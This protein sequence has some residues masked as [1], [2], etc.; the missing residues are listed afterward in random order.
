MVD[1]EIQLE[2]AAAQDL[3]AARRAD[4]NKELAAQQSVLQQNAAEID[5]LEKLAANK[6][7]I[8]TFVAVTIVGGGNAL[9]NYL[10]IGAVPIL[11]DAIDL[12]AGGSLSLLLMTLEGGVRWKAQIWVW[13]LTFVEFIP[14]ADIISP[15][16]FGAGIAL[17]IAWREG[18]KAQKKLTRILAAEATE[19]N[20]SGYEF[21]E[22]EV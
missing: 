9:L 13:V 4:Q 11:G 6:E 14:A 8:V 18:T 12:L 15:Q 21:G 16:A 2:D 22:G 3:R 1:E 17:F 7:K 20:V 19:I 5:R 10:G